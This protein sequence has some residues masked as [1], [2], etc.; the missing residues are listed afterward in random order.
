MPPS[1][2]LTRCLLAGLL[3]FIALQNQDDEEH[4][5]ILEEDEDEEMPNPEGFTY[6]KRVP[7]K[8]PVF[9]FEEPWELEEDYEEEGDSYDFI[10]KERKLGVKW[11][12][13]F[14]YHSMLRDVCS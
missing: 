9:P 13:S 6:R 4:R 2:L 12:V 5:R 11:V 7:S 14:P 1:L 3:Y 10:N 8:E